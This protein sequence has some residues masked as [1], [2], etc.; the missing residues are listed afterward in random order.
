MKKK[1]FLIP[2]LLLVAVGVVAIQARASVDP[3]NKIETKSFNFT[4]FDEIRV[5]GSFDVEYLQSPGNTWA[6]EVTAPDNII[7]YVVVKRHE[8]GISLSLKGVSTDKDFTLRAKITAPSLE[9]ISLSGA[10][11]FSANEINVRGLDLEASGASSFNFKKIVSSDLEIN[12]SGASV[13]NIKGVDT[14][15]FDLN[16]SGASTADIIIK[17]GEADVEIS[18]ASLA[19]LSGSVGNVELEASGAST[20]NAKSFKANSG[21]LQASGASKIDASIANLI[22]QRATGG[23]TINNF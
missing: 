12:L 1:Y 10:S 8:E 3:S 23:S 21:S 14:G 20:I 19:N 6:I 17:A 22:H 5:S 7:P 9:E 18:G 15:E 13:A 2:L 11:S 16:L 4:N